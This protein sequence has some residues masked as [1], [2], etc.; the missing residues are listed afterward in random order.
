MAKPRIRTIKPEFWTD[1]KIAELPKATAL[2]FIALWNFADDQGI[3]EADARGLALRIP[4]YRSQDVEKMLMAL[5]RAGLVKRSTVDGLVMVI[6]WDHQKIDRP[7]DGKW[8]HKEIQWL[9]FSDSSKDREE[10]LPVPD[11]TVSDRKGSDHA[12]LVQAPPAPAP[13]DPDPEPVNHAAKEFIARYCE[14]F[15]ARWKLNPEVRGKQAGVAKRV[16]K[17]LPLERALLYL[18]AFFQMPDA[19][20]VK[21]KHPLEAFEGKLNEITVYASTG[22]FTSNLQVRHLEQKGH[23]LSQL[24]RI[25]RGLL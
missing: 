17:D 11:R 25:E 7:R 24:E 5:W 3:I 8:K 9:V 16:V 6:H 12:T 1:A 14:L 2:F 20:L 18:E 4:I 15:K 13:A 19:W 22:E 21:T 10:S 23:T